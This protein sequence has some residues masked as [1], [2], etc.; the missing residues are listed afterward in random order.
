M[1]NIESLVLENL[2][3]AVYACDSDL[4]LTYLNG[5]CAGLAGLNASDAPG[6]KCYDVFGAGH[7]AQMQPCPAK[8]AMQKLQPAAASNINYKTPAG[9]LKQIRRSAFPIIN[10]GAADGA[11]VYLHEA[12]NDSRPDQIDIVNSH[13][14]SNLGYEIRTPMT[15]IM[16]FTE[17][18][19]QTNLNPDQAKLAGHIKTSSESL[20]SIITSLLEYSRLASGDI[21]L[22]LNEFSFKQLIFEAVNLLMGKAVQ[23]SLKIY[24]TIDS[25]L[26]Y[27]L[28]GDD[29]K[30]K[31]IL[32]NL[33]DNAIKFSAQGEIRIVLSVES[34]TAETALI[35]VEISDQG[36]CVAQENLAGIFLPFYQVDNGITREHHGIGLGLT[37]AEHYVKMMGGEKIHVESAA[38]SG[39]RFH[40][41]INF[42]RAASAKKNDGAASAAGEKPSYSIGCKILVVEDNY[43]NIEVI[44]RLLKICECDFQVVENGLQALDKIKSGGRFDAILM[45]INLPEIS[46]IETA[47]MIRKM[48]CVT[49]IIAVTAYTSANDKLLCL[50]AGMNDYLTKPINFNL[51]FNSIKTHCSGPPDK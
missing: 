49:P 7:C 33:L 38:G 2:G 34:E 10:G 32:L 30:L 18:L 44:C 21:A 40:F 9:V 31:I 47:K 26:K 23:K 19:T 50:N 45:D 14:V 4:N 43:L 22:E 37:L 3:V 48:G 15:N 13:F 46:G 20:L 36:I 24:Y 42:A 35:K 8:I 29:A 51:L 1:N 12:G 27:N 17:M 25:N 16:G 28:R 6:R 41:S 11:V 5:Q 39:S